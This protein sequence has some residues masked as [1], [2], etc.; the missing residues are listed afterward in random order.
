MTTQ[1]AQ[2]RS[3]GAPCYTEM[4]REQILRILPHRPP[5]LMVDRLINVVSGESAVGIK[6][7]S[8][9]DWYFKGHFEKKAVMPGVMIIE[10]LAQ[11]AAAL[12]MD[13]LGVYDKDKLVYFMGIDEA[14]FRKMV[15]PGDV[16][17]LEV[18]KTHRRGN[19][20]RFKGVAKVN[21][22]VVAEAVKTAMIADN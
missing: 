8:Q 7:T 15:F 4:T 17:H 11:T 1:D 5:M 12:A 19:V 21:G 20:W 3:M 9:D 13:H 14:R 6:E 16:L 22:E 2:A 10:A 18:F